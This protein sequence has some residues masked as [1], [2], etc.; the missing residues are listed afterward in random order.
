MNIIKLKDVIMPDSMPQAELFNKYLKG[1]YAYWIQMRYIVPF[2]FMRHEGYVACEEDLTKLLQKP[3]GTYPKPYGA[4]A[5][6]VYD[7]R[8]VCYVD[9]LETDRINN[10]MEYRL[11]NRYTP[12]SDITIEELKKFRTW[13]ATELMSFDLN[14]YGV[15]NHVL[16]T[17]IE[18]YIL[19]YYANR[20]FDDTI[21]ILSEFG[22]S[23]VSYNDIT[24]GCSCQ[25]SSDLSGL[26]NSNVSVCDPISIYR[27]NIKA[28]MV[29]MFSNIN[30]WTKFAPEFI[31]EFKKYID[32]IIRLNL[33]LYK[34]NISDHLQDC[35][36]VSTDP[37]EELISI[38]NRLSNSLGYIYAKDLTGHKNYISDALKDWSSKLY[39]IM[40]W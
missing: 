16:F 1:K 21:K 9:Q 26:Y 4:P 30:F 11:K 10:I 14:K 29:E 34:S 38:L 35:G 2:D 19:G 37:Q 12:D 8:I 18:G 15:M 24:K 39:E 17:E 36:C 33:P 40:E 22:G 32:N 28:K 7:E 3:D 5:L 13:L 31:L 20:M 27:G 23:M 25:S 6:D